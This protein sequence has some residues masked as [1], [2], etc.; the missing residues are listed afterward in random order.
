MEICGES[1]SKVCP[2]FTG[3]GWSYRLFVEKLK[4]VQFTY[5]SSNTFQFSQREG[6]AVY[7]V[8]SFNGSAYET[9]CPFLSYFVLVDSVVQI[10][11]ANCDCRS[12]N[13]KLY[14]LMFSCIMLW[15]LLT[16]LRKRYH[17]LMFKV[18]I[19]QSVISPMPLL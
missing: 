1:Y 12:S 14:F 15:S 9:V 5:P 3:S 13:V 2:S 10:L 11:S 8:L 7:D 17:D 19:L 4:L 6:N 18:I 16:Y